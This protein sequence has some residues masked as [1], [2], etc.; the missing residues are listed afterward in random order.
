[1]PLGLLTFC[2]SGGGVGGGGGSSGC[3][4]GAEKVEVGE[5]MVVI[6][7]VVVY[8]FYCALQ[9]LEFYNNFTLSHRKHSFC[10]FAYFFV[11]DTFAF[12]LDVHLV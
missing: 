5:L 9:I 7:I 3:V 1:M 6:V 10:V 8:W 2:R 11:S 4:G 12:S